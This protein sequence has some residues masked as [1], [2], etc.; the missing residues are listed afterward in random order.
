MSSALPSDRAYL[1]EEGRRLLEDRVHALA[2]VVDELHAVLDDPERISVES[3]LGHALLGKHVGDSVEVR[4][5]IGAYRCTI[6]SACRI[7]TDCTG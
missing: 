1:T 7:Q 5:P 2:S 3:P 4:V 6:V